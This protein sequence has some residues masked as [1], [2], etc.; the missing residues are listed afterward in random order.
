MHNSPFPQTNQTDFQ[1]WAMKIGNM[2]RK[3]G[4]ERDVLSKNP[5]SPRARSKT[6]VTRFVKTAVTDSKTEKMVAKM[7][8]KTEKIEEMRS[9]REEVREDIIIVVVVVGFL[10]LVLVGCEVCWELF[11]DLGSVGGCCLSEV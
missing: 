4:Q 9:W 1:P 11:W 8:R 3:K 5:T 6:L 7:E 10:I 2:E